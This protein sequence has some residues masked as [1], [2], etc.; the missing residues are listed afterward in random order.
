MTDAALPDLGNLIIRPFGA[1]T[2]LTS[3]GFTTQECPS[4]DVG[5]HSVGEVHRTVSPDFA[6]PVFLA[7]VLGDRSPEWPAQPFLDRFSR[8]FR[9]Q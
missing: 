9:V 1:D 7:S 8:V 4:T 2:I 3:A 5:T 6:M